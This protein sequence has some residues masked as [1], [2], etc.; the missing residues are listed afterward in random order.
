[1]RLSAPLQA[2][3][4]FSNCSKR[5]PMTGGLSGTWGME[6]RAHVRYPVKLSLQFLIRTGKLVA[7]S[8][9]GVSV[10]M[11]SAGLL[12]RSLKRLRDGE[13]VVA[14]L[15]WP[16]VPDGKAMVLLVHGH[17]IWMKGQLIGM[18]VSHYGFVDESLFPAGDIEN[19]AKLTLPRHLTPTKSAPPPHAGVHPWKKGVP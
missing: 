1:M 18:S 6:R 12:F 11:S 9:E 4:W 15:H 14:A 3:D 16:I 19:L 10:N 8:G 5:Q 13:R 17:V 2:L 7:A